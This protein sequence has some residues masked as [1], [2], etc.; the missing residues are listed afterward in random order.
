[1]YGT[2]QVKLNVSEAVRDYLVYQCRQSNSLINSAIYH[3][4][5]AHFEQCPRSEFFTGDEFRSGFK[6]QRVKTAKYASL[7]AELQD[8]PHYKVLGGQAAQ[9]SLKSVAEAF[10][11][12]NG[13]LSNFFKGEA[14]RPTI[15][16]YRTKGGLAPIAYPAQAVQFD[17]ESGQCRLPVSLEVGADV[18]TLLDV[19]EIWING[20]VGIKP[21][22]VCE[23]RI[24]PRNNELYAEYVYEYGNQGATCHLSLDQT[25]ALG[26]DH[27]VDNWLTCVA[28]LGQSFILDGRK[29][30]SINQLYNKRVAELKEGKAQG[31][32]DD[33][34]ASLTEKRNRVMRDAINKAARFIVNYCLQNRIGVVV[35]GWNQRQK[36]G[37]NLGTRNNQTFVQIPTG[38]LKTRLQQ[39]C[40]AVGIQFLET[41]ESY[42]SKA[43]FLD[44]DFLPTFGAKPASWKPSGK[45]EKRGQYRT[46]DGSTLNSDCNGVAN[47]ITKVATQL[48]LNLVKVGRAVLTLPKRY[49]VFKGLSTV[50][51]ERCEACLQTA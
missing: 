25:Q 36:N 31:F 6:L 9:Q 24:L 26:I 47:I 33:Q 10:T 13:I 5:Q 40:E 35:F 15:P 3:A 4:K 30:K 17:L 8:N 41:E 7:C 43:S 49:D 22:Q 42:T 23:V 29:L 34:L 12:Y 16:R 27:G 37:S 1:M 46:A 50:Y 32:W 2:I 51:R 38:R 19:K 44:H 45:R 20:C 14:E 18:K 21:S 39:L 48:G 28:T 11:S